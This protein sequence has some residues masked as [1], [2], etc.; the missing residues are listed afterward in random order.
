MLVLLTKA[1]QN[2][3][4]PQPVAQSRHRLL[5]NVASHHTATPPELIADSEQRAL[6]EALPSHDDLPIVKIVAP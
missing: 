3:S 5:R 2:N 4:A 1:G 6:A